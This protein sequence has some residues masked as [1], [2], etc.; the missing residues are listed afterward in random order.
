[1]SVALY[2]DHNVDV[3]VMAAL[4]SVAVDVI[5]A[6]DDAQARTGDRDLLKRATEMKRVIVTHDEDFL[7]IAALWQGAGQPFAGVAYC[8]QSALTTGELI[9]ALMLFALGSDQADVENIVTY[10]PL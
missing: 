4:S 3:H 6:R 2:L 10:L 8:H 1:M 9:E 5:C 7:R